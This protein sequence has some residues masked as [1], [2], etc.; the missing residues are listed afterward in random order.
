MILS[1]MRKEKEDFELNMEMLA[2]Q[3]ALLMNATGNFKRKIKPSDL[4]KSDYVDEAN[5]LEKANGEDSAEVKKKLQE[6]LLSTFADS[7][8][9]TL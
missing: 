2:W 5:E 3:T 1:N 7:H 4:Y 9:I 6:E 8:S